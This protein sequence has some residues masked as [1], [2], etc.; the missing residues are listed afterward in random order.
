MHT[1]KLQIKITECDTACI[2]MSISNLGYSLMLLLC[3]IY[4]LMDATYSALLRCM[5]WLNK[6]KSKDVLL[7]LPT[8]CDSHF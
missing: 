4:G 1:G 6:N 7:N 2:Y 8:K 3:V 5:N